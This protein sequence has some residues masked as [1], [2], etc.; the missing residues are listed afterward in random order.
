[1]DFSKSRFGQ[2]AHIKVKWKCHVIGK[3]T[4]KQNKTAVWSL[5]SK[6]GPQQNDSD[7]VSFQLRHKKKPITDDSFIAVVL[8]SLSL[9]IKRKKKES[10]FRRQ[11]RRTAQKMSTLYNLSLSAGLRFHLHNDIINNWKWWLADRTNYFC[12]LTE[13]T[14]RRGVC[15]AV[16]W[17]GNLGNT[18]R[19]TQTLQYRGHKDVV[20]V[21]LLKN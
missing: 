11:D 13:T 20:T 8:H 12:Q 7:Y 16:S 17:A 1:M 6:V 3:Q 15:R 19:F 18:S 10:F 21:F 2:T 4:K 5:N 14:M 9:V